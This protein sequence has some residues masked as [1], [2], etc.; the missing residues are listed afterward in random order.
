MN[1]ALRLRTAAI[2]LAAFLA[3]GA[4]AFSYYIY[5]SALGVA[6]RGAGA[7]L[8]AIARAAAAEFDGDAARALFL[9]EVSSAAEFQNRLSR[10]P[11]RPEFEA[12]RN[13]LKRQIAAQKSVGFNESNLYFFVIDPF[14]KNQVRW[15]VMAHARAFTGEPYVQRPEMQAITSGGAESQFT[16]VYL[17]TASRREWMSGYAAVR[18]SQ[19]RVVGVMEA[20]LDVASVRAMAQA[21]ARSAF[22]VIGGVIG[23]ALLTGFGLFRFM[24]SLKESNERLSATVER[25]NLNNAN[26]KLLNEDLKFA[27]E[28][29]SASERRYRRLLEGSRD[30]IFSLDAQFKFASANAAMRSVLGVGADRAIGRAFL[31]ALQESGAEL[32]EIESEILKER[33]RELG[34]K[35]PAF[36]MLI[37]IRVPA[38]QEL[39]SY[40]F[41]FDWIAGENGQGEILGKAEQQDEDA[42]MAHFQA[43][44]Q[45]YRIEN[46]FL[47]AEDAA[48]RVTRNLK[49]FAEPG[50]AA[51]V[52]IAIR[53]ALFNAIEHGNLAIT[54]EEKSRAMAEDRYLELV[55]ARRSAPEFSDR[56]VAIASVLNRREFAVRI[57]DEGAGFDHRKRT[58][59]DQL[60]A[61]LEQH[62]RGL[63][64]IRAAFDEVRYNERGNELTL[65]KRFALS[66]ESA[67]TTDSERQMEF[68]ESTSS[69][70]GADR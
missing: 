16:S 21:E 4:P 32:E 20:A 48:S 33:L 67:G 13:R 58:N 35:K 61:G 63:M 36:E 5:L 25:L 6:Q 59:P 14:E 30:F 8:A 34:E 45:A 39:R 41:R 65:I 42:L 22:A 26:M 24:V 18:D 31:T 23:L 70:E 2:G 62:G 51:A 3:I 40:R 28:K 47:L 46:Q 19:G 43:E 10:A 57:T 1:D 7:E 56:R 49:R 53:E 38:I 27:R 9:D 66:A 29:A 60:N 54:F 15:G 11:A 69:Y 37:D 44:K 68:R 64:M 50:D 52:R 55:R 17:S 12:L